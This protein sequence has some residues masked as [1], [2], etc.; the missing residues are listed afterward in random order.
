MMRSKYR[1]SRFRHGAEEMGEDV[2]PSAYIVNLAD[3]MLVLACGFMVAMVAHYQVD[4]TAKPIDQETME[5]VDPSEMPE[6]I[7]SEG[8]SYIEAGKVYMD[9]LTGDLYMIREADG[10]SSGESS[11]GAGEASDYDDEG[12]SSASAPGFGLP[13]QSVS[14]GGQ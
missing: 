4:I 3:C 12:S 8:S 10:E 9:P 6:D 5:E 7:T 11:S 1:S 14:N 13:S 2:N